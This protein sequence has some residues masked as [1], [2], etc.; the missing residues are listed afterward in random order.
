[1]T[2]K[3]LC[4]QMYIKVLMAFEVVTVTNALQPQLWGFWWLI[5]R[6]WCSDL[7]H[8]RQTTVPARAIKSCQ[9]QCTCSKTA[10]LWCQRHHCCSLVV[11]L[12]MLC[13]TRFVSKYAANFTLTNQNVLFVCL[14]AVFC[15]R[16]Y[17]LCLHVI[18]YLV[19]KVPKYWHLLMIL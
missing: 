12:Y 10:L 6:C 13:R 19:M 11:V 18:V 3:Y 14:R 7:L 9:G 5:A 8:I 17:T 15:H 4:D 16:C 1:M 2:A